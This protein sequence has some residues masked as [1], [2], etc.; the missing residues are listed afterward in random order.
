MGHA[1]R[2]VALTKR[3][4]THDEMTNAADAATALARARN[5]DGSLTIF[6]DADGKEMRLAPAVGDVV[7]DLL[8]LLARNNMVTI[9]PTGAELTTQQAAD[10]LN[11]SRPYLSGL[12][13]DGTIDHIQVGSHR[14]VRLE[15]L[16]AYKAKRDA[17]RRGALRE[18]A[19]LGQD[20]DAD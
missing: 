12:L 10:L 4:P 20:F 14:R 3:L 13:K 17:G 8:G 9:V 15:D 11:V 7:I 6:V 5:D 2:V 1:D 19:R 18:M 16:M